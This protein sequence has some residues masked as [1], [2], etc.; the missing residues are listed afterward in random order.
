MAHFTFEG[1]A[2]VSYLGS[3]GEWHDLGSIIDAS[4]ELVPMADVKGKPIE[5]PGIESHTITLSGELSPEAV[6]PLGPIDHLIWGP[7]LN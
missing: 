1:G 6:E 3:D 5:M 7:L 4:I 2:T